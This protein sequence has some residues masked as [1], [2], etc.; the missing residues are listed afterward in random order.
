MSRSQTHNAMPARSRPLLSVLAPACTDEARTLT[1]RLED[2]IRA[3][4]DD[5]RVEIMTLTDERARGLPGRAAACNALAQEARGAWLLFLDADMRP[6]ANDF[7]GRWLSVIAR[8]SPWIAFGPAPLPASPTALSLQSALERASQADPALA[9][10]A[11]E[12]FTSNLLVRREIFAEAAFDESLAGAGREDAEWARRAGRHAPILHV[13]GPA[14]HAP[15]VDDE[16]LLERYRE[17]GLDFAHLVRTHPE[18]ARTL[19]AY[20]TAR[21]FALA[22][23]LRALRPLFAHAARDPGRMTPPRVRAMA[24]NLWRASWCGEALK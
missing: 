21:L 22:P 11:R 16:T 8:E 4:K 20:A 19:P 10:A 15:A 1:A 18:L 2:E 14:A 7:L 12:A 5:G 3:R 23:G 13:E 9:R 24:A 17:A 6:A